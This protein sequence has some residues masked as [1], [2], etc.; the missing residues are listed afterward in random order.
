MIK[1]ICI[2]GAGNVASSLAPALQGAG[3]R[4]TQVFSRDFDNAAQLAGTVGAEPVSQLDKLSYA[5]MFIFSVKDNCIAQCI[6]CIPENLC[7]AVFAHTSGSV[8]ME[9]FKGKR[10]KHCGVIYPLQTFS[11]TLRIGFRDVPL[12]IEAS[13]KFA[14]EI[15]R[16][17][18]LSVSDKVLETD[19]EK[20]K[21]IHLAAV[22]ACNFTNHM[23]AVADKIL[24]D[25]GICFDIL[26]PLIDESVRKI[27]RMKPADAQ[28]GP[29]VRGDANV[30]AEHMSMLADERLKQI[31]GIMT[32]DISEWEQ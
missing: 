32:K 12:L 11:K 4:I 30:I 1:D 9:V 24:E 3:Y 25:K 6:D 10:L 13:D 22:F 23:Y 28:T 21:N 8:G 29:S 14:L 17:L 18:A 2:I 27:H 20:R 16:S 7:D 5:D 31:Y 15:I 26:L 19:S